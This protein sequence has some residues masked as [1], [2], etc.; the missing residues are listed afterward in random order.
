MIDETPYNSAISVL[1]LQKN[2]YY[3]LD[4]LELAVEAKCMNFFSLTPVQN[5]LTSIW[6]GN[7]EV[8]TGPKAHSI[9]NS[10]NLAS[11]FS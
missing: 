4:C 5:L 2:P 10:T 11:V 7:T 1:L 9:V 8:Q 6:N 3:N